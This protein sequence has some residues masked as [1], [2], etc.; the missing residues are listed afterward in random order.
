MGNKKG[1][2]GCLGTIFN[3]VWI[4]YFGF[5]L[6]GIIFGGIVSIFDDSE[7][8]NMRL[9]DG[10]GISSYNVV[11][12]VNEDNTIDVTENLVVDFTSSATPRRKRSKSRISSWAISPL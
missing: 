9:A 12:D 7:D 3:F 2:F 4:C 5:M 8:E 10:F 6:I 1:C 11:L